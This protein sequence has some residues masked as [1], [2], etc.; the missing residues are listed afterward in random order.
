MPAIVI[1]CCYIRM[2]CNIG[3][4]SEA[5][6]TEYLQLCILY[7]KLRKLLACLSTDIEQ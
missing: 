6:G 2:K 5:V 4:F 7:K 3:H 1:L